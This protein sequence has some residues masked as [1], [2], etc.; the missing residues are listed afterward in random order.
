VLCHCLSQRTA[1]IL[2]SATDDLLQLGQLGSSRV[3]KGKHDIN[4]LR[5]DCREERAE[6]KGHQSGLDLA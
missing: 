5:Q 1:L 2:L 3:K 6:A 4:L